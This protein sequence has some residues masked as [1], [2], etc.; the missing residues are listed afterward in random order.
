MRIA[1]VAVVAIGAVAALA[2]CGSGTSQTNGAESQSISIKGSDTMVHL[3]S[4]W[5]EAYNAAHPQARV[6][7]DG[8]GSGTGIKA[9]TQGAVDIAASSRSMKDIE[10]T[11]AEE[12]GIESAEHIV[13]YD[14]IAVVVRA[15]NPVKT[16]TV[17]ELKGIFTGRIT[18]W[19]ALGGP[20]HEIVPISRESSSG[21]YVYFKE[22]VMDNEDYTANALRFTSSA[23]IINE[24]SS[25]AYAIA[26]VG[27][28]YAEHGENIHMVG[29]ETEQHPEGALPTDDF[30]LSNAYPIA[31]PL[32][33]YSLAVP[34]TET[35]HFL[36][37][38]KGTEGQ[39]I[40][41]EEGYVP[42]PE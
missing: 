34:R 40:V 19:S 9:L 6:T 41:R 25:N 23:Q 7:V 36:E 24:I 14:G 39:T 5:A 26:Y 38:V 20:D 31:R 4:A 37:W 2:G 13:G 22:A 16:L 3:A 28:G 1:A 15:D 12:N 21:T 29:V 33:F 17:P 8:G 18:N 10:K 11:T 30:I 35:Q 42:L 32:Y 27:R